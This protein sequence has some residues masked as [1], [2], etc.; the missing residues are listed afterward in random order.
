MRIISVTAVTTE[1]I[2]A[3]GDTQYK[4][5]EYLDGAFAS[6][7]EYTPHAD[8]PE[9]VIASMEVEL[10]VAGQVVRFLSEDSKRLTAAF[11]SQA[12]L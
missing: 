1:G 6:V 4:C 11:E 3:T 10:E 5:F 7:H 8:R 9:L 12:W 2:E